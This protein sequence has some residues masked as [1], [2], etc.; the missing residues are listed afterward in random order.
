MTQ[1]IAKQLSDAINWI[2]ERVIALLMLI[3]VLDVWLG[4]VDRY[5]FHWQLPWPEVVARYFMIWMA[6]LAISA[7]ISRREHIGLTTLLDKMSAKYTRPILIAVDCIC[8]VM[9]TCIG[10]FGIDF[11]IKGGQK[12]AFIFDMTLFWPY[13]ALPVAMGLAALQTL[14]VMLRD[15][16]EHSNFD[17][18]ESMI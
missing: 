16:G 2:V 5:V 14:L 15:Q 18:S 10:Y 4:V 3:L 1:Q 12:F 9:F 8:F 13:L 17:A 7:G 11:A 6:L